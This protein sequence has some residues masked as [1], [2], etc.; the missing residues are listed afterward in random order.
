VR[1]FSVSRNAADR[2]ADARTHPPR[3]FD[4][5]RVAKFAGFNLLAWGGIAFLFAIQAS[6]RLGWS[7]PFSRSLLN[8]LLGFAPYAL[9]TPIVARVASKFSFTPESRFPST[10]AHGV[11]ALWFVLITGLIM[12]AVDWSAGHLEGTLLASMFLGVFQ[13]IAINAVIYG[14]IATFFLVRAYAR[15]VQEHSIA[16]AVLH[17]ELAEARLNALTSRLQPHFLF[18]TLNAIAALVR[19]D[20]RRAERLLARLSDLLRHALRDAEQSEVTLENELSFVEKYAEVQETRFGPR[21]NVAFDIDPDVLSAKVP[22][23]LLQPIV[24]NAF[25]HGLAPRSGSG[26]IWVRAQE[27]EDRLLL[28]VTDDGIGLPPAGVQDGVGLR[29]TRARLRQLYGE[30]FQFDL[31]GPARGG[32]LCT[33]ILPLRRHDAAVA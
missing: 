13:Y 11:S 26:S 21:L 17:S 18:N 31:T 2:D 30:D 15:H 10:I 24:E 14:L 6:S 25:R 22:P 9:L 23:L 1:R 28:S 19:E 5:R 3:R 12:G 27:Q 8:A 4:V 7:Q 33:I 32:A 16:A 20:P 29:T